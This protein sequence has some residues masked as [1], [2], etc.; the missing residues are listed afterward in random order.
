M[1]TPPLEFLIVHVLGRIK[2]NP[3]EQAQET[4]RLA[5]EVADDIKRAAAKCQSVTHIDG[6]PV[7]IVG[8]KMTGKTSVENIEITYFSDRETN[9]KE[10]SKQ[11]FYAL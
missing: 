10:Y 2:S 6:C 9:T 5:T 3:L 11:E 1:N 7:S 4:V 8:L